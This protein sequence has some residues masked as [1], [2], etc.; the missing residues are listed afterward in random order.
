MLSRRRLLALPVVLPVVAAG[1]SVAALAPAPT[2][3]AVLTLDPSALREVLVEAN[4]H[5][6]TLVAEYHRLQA[7]RLA[8][9]RAAGVL[10]NEEFCA[11]AGFDADKLRS[12]A[13]S[14]GG[15]EGHAPNSAVIADASRAPRTRLVN[16]SAVGVET[17]PQD[18]N[19]DA[20]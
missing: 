16:G 2:K 9:M 19:A 11:A 1:A 7:R 3:P 13:R 20:A 4:R 18:A 17:G 12:I 14:C 10:S 5:L 15:V 8:T 6:A